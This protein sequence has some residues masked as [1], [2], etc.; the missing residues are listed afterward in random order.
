MALV[1]ETIKTIKEF[2]KGL[3]FKTGV[4]ILGACL[5]FYVLSFAQMLLPISPVAK[6]VLWTVL[7]G[8][9]KAAQYSA[10]LIL[11]KAGIKKILSLRKTPTESTEINS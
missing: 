11:G 9:A 10:L 3:S 7:F 4:I 2:I 5:V 1:K 6:G 8:C